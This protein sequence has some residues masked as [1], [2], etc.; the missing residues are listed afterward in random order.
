MAAE[1]YFRFQ[2]RHVSSYGTFLCVITQ[3]FSQ[4][5][6]T[7]D[8]AKCPIDNAKFLI[9]VLIG[10]VPTR[11]RPKWPNRTSGQKSVGRFSIGKPGSL[12][13]KH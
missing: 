1:F 8:D 9:F 4:M 2:F 5:T 3:N 10:E 6:Q 7:G 11:K 13:C 12:V